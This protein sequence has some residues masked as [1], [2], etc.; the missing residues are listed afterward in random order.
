MLINQQYSLADI[1]TL[2]SMGVPWCAYFAELSWLLSITDQVINC[3]QIF[4][5]TRGER[6]GWNELFFV[7]NAPTLR[8][9]AW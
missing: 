4:N 5:F 2:E 6:R 7:Q 8:L 3:N 1:H 9:I